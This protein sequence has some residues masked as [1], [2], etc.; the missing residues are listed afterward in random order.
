[1]AA[2]SRICCRLRAL[3]GRELN[4]KMDRSSRM[5]VRIDSGQGTTRS[6]SDSETG[7]ARGPFVRRRQCGNGR[8]SE[9]VRDWR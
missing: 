1:M 4:S 2:F 3:L 8:V 7:S 6:V 9:D 5:C